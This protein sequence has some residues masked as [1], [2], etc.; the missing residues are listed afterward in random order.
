MPQ[1]AAH[2]SNNVQYDFVFTLSSNLSRLRFVQQM[3]RKC[4][5][6][7]AS[8]IQIYSMHREATSEFTV[9]TWPRATIQSV[10]ERECL[11]CKPWN[12]IS[13]IYQRVIVIDRLRVYTSKPEKTHLL[14]ILDNVEK[15]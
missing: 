6:N 9:R 8:A 10:F 5:S 4:A 12:L 7:S 14:S 13:E 2:S 11:N 1:Y 15:K 3:T